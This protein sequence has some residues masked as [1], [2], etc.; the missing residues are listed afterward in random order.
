MFHHRVRCAAASSMSMST[1]I[2]AASHSTMSNR[3]TLVLPLLLLRPNNSRCQ[4]SN[5]LLGNRSPS[6]QTTCPYHR[7]HL[8]L[9]NSEAAVWLADGCQCSLHDETI[10]PAGCGVGNG[11]RMHQV[12]FLPSGKLP[13]S[14]H[15]ISTLILRRHCK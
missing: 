11:C 6:M 7:R 2:V 8:T 12:S 9:S 13:M 15:H 4:C 14:R 5:S 3:L 10:S 1:P